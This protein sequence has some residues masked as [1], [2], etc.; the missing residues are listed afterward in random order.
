MAWGAVKPRLAKAIRALRANL[1]LQQF[2]QGDDESTWDGRTACTHVVLQALA[3]I[4]LDRKL[5]IDQISALAG[6]WREVNAQGQP[7]GMNN[8]EFET[9]CRRLGL[10]Y[11]VVFGLSASD[12]VRYSNRGP[13]FY[14]MRHGSHP[15]MKGATYQ[16]TRARA[17]FA[18][19]G[20]QT[21]LTG[22]ENGRHAV[23]LL[24]YRQTVSRL[25]RKVTGYRAWV[26]DPNHGSAARPERPAF[27]EMTVEQV[28]R[29][30]EA[31][32]ET[33]AN[34]VYCAIPTEALA[35]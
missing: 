5:S 12:M 34:N 33:G 30:Y 17:P 21:Q 20:G 31:F 23:L 2:G 32:L 18:I 16:G 8:V 1:W 9:V 15:D 26:K 35:A 10:P 6:Y 7:R 3:L 13:V 19:R 4:W 24:G 27:D 14:G 11:T 29:E 28:K 22:F 25:T